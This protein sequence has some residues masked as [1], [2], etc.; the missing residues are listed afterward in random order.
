MHCAPQMEGDT[1]EWRPSDGQRLA[2]VQCDYLE[3]CDPDG[4]RLFA[5]DSKEACVE[6]YACRSSAVPLL[7]LNLAAASRAAFDTCIESIAARECPRS[8][9]AAALR[10]SLSGRFPWDF[11]PWKPQCGMPALPTATDGAPGRGDVCLTGSLSWSA[12]DC[13]NG[14]YCVTIEEIPRFGLHACGVCQNVSKLGE[15]CSDR[16]GCES[17]TACIQGKCTALLEFGERCTDSTQ[18]REHHCDDGLCAP[19]PYVQQRLAD[20]VGRACATSSDCDSQVG[21]SCRDDRCQPLPE[22]GE[23]CSSDGARF[24]CRLGSYCIEDRCTALGC[25]V[26]EGEPCGAGT[27]CTKG[28]CEDGLCVASDLDE[29][30]RCNSKCNSGL[31]CE[32]NTCVVDAKSKLGSAC[33]YDTDCASDYCS[34]SY[35]LSCT[36]SMCPLPRC[37][38]C[39]TCAKPP[40]PS[41][42]E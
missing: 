2:E 21:L 28:F 18:C 14:T 27:P 8:T 13:Q 36:G 17:G 4:L 31:K 32:N 25:S 16:A 7:G 34:R 15:N 1:T 19:L 29:G 23:A 39:G 6:Y 5:N 12:V 10:L 24:A 30:D 40:T 11:D 9:F 3:R 22:V 41:D 37:D 38:G 35:D 20:V 33:D 26:D 42:C